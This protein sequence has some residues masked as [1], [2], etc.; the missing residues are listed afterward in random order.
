MRNRRGRV[1][2]GCRTW[3][4]SLATVVAS[5]AFGAPG[6]FAQQQPIAEVRDELETLPRAR[7]ATEE[8]EPKAKKADLLVVP[9][10]LTNP[11]LGTGAMLTGVVFYNPNDA[12]QPWISGVGVMATSTGTKGAGAFHSMSLDHDRFRFL[13]FA[14]YADAKLKFYGI[15]ADAGAR[16][17]HVDLEDKGLGGLAQAQVRLA[18]HLYGGVRL[19]YLNVDS[20]AEIPHPNYPD[21]N[22]PP[23]ELKSTLAMLGP[24]LTY[25]SRNSSLNPS[26][27]SYVTAFWTFGSKFLGSDFSHDKLQVG[28]NFYAPVTKT[29]VA[30]FRGSTCSVSKRVPFYDLC[31]YGQSGDLRGYEAG[32]YRDRFTW[33]FQG[34]FRQKL[35]GKFGAVAFGGVGGVAPSAD[36]IGDSKVLP[37][38][39]AGLRYQASKSNNVNL[40][41]DFAA[42]IDGHAVYFGIGEAF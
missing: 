39:G 7:S 3:A 16:G 42:G 15:G 21:L 2:A 23:L 18:N 31:M 20:T 36:Q 6:A 30:A 13:V 28:A 32:R 8:P 27:G 24:S 22:L 4:L 33:A 11:A 37:S 29:T 19:E 41:L 35:F 10:P 17:V 38:V 1:H 14:G 34:E 5:A 25:D 12:P 40:R 26:R 9:I